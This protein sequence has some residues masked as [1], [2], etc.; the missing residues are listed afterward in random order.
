M[1]SAPR[2]GRRQLLQTGA[3]ALGGAGAGWSASAL[4]RAQAAPVAPGPPT[5]EAAVTGN[6]LVGFHGAHQAG[7][8]TPPQAHLSLLGLDLLDRDDRDA[9]RRL[10]V[11]LSDDASRLTAG[12]A[13]LADT[14]PELSAAPARLTVTFGLGPALTGGLP[15]GARVAP[16]PDFS[17]DRLDDA[18]GQTDLA[19]QLCAD[20]PLTLAHTRRM[21][22]KDVRGLAELRW[23]Q[24]GY[25]RARGTE[26][27]G[28][29]M[30][31]VMGQVDGT[32][33]P[34][35]ADP[36]FAD[37][38]WSGEE[39]FVGGTFM[40]VRRIRARMESWDRVDRAGREASVGRRLDNGAPITGVRE[41]DEPD[42]E[43][44]DRFGLPVI[45]PASHVARA[46]SADPVERF[47][48]RA[49]NYTV[50]DATQASGEDSGLVFIAF[51]AD[52]ERQ[53]VP[54]QRR[55]ADLD[56]LNEWVTTIGSA[57]YAIPP[58]TADGEHVAQSLLA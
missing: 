2:W 16:L 35:E 49:Y 52:L 10:L 56:R 48:R 57:V 8:A 37:L 5:V 33:N 4:G 13:A 24:D 7:V 27:D 41:H 31:N 32:V 54:V 30:R 45:D 9:L 15:R 23:I 25:R 14:E 47:H 11:L 38:V 6:Q 55:L 12:R 22:V 36:D 29:T 53:F 39:G 21:L 40:V 28:T 26:P 58:G 46:R 3:V 44:T 51:A 19:I 17:T 43:A 20:D 1:T 42:F 34:V 50:P 18:W